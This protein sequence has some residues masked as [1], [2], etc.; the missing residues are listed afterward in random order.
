MKN[1]WVFWLLAGCLW[2]G[3]ALAGGGDPQKTKELVAVLQSPASLFDK[4]RACQQLSEIGTK[5]AVPA[6]AELLPDQHLSA[7]ARSGLEGISDPTAAS[8]LRAAL[9]LV[10][11]S[12]LAGVINSLGALRDPKAVPALRPFA[13]DPVSGV[14]KE[15]LFALGLIGN[16]EAIAILRPALDAGPEAARSDAAAACLLAAEKHIAGGDAKTAMLLYDAVR[17]AKVPATCHA[18]ATRGAI[19]ARQP[20]GMNFLMEQLTDRDPVVRNAALLTIREIP[21]PALA[22]ALNAEIDKAPPDLEVQLLGALADC[23]NAASLQLLEAK[24]GGGDPEIRRTALRVLAGVAD[25]SEAQALLKVVVES[26]R[27]EE[28]ELA[29]SGLER[30]DGAAVND[31]VLRELQSARNPAAR[32]QLIGLL[33]SRGAANAA[34]ELLK[35]AADSDETVSVA[36]AAALESLAGAKEVPGLIAL[37]KSL[38]ARP[39]RDAAEKAICRAAKSEGNG[40]AASEAVL[41]EM[42]RSTDPVEKNSLVRVLVS[43]G[44]TKALPALIASM[45]DSND[46]VAANAVENLGYWPDP[47]PVE[48]LLSV[49][50]A[51]AKPE[52]HPRAIASVIQLATIA[53]DE[54]QGPDTLVLGW[55]ERCGAA[56]QTAAERRRI[57]SVLG[58]IPRLESFRLLLPWLDQPDLQAEA[59]IAVVQIAPAL[60]DS[61]ESAAVKKA[62]QSIAATAK[63]AEIRGQAEKLAQSNGGASKTP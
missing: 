29:A 28:I 63:N 48:A 33:A 40:D 7:Y 61:E 58:R 17:T 27:T 16:G 39:A 42:E 24:A 25:P 8:A 1:R 4:A 21:G 62:L 49:A 3:H 12:L 19:L 31:L 45:N 15:A 5:D 13:E 36:A 14:A 2:G 38:K 50:G 60:V 51:S 32:V 57:I 53:A 37:T 23:H 6:L 43:L 44:Y 22:E 54:H 56:A 20:N 26:E 47:A 9:R 35:Q 52:L 11:G 59:Q 30:L 46:A 55:L 18:A 10:K 34:P 41:A